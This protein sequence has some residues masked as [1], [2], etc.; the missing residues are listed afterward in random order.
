M[1]AAIVP[2]S[3]GVPPAGLSVSLGLFHRRWFCL[4]DVSGETPETAGGTPALPALPAA[5]GS[6]RLANLGSISGLLASVAAGASPARGNREARPPSSL[7]QSP[8]PPRRLPYNFHPTLVL[9]HS[10]LH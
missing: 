5:A 2:G 10:S 3:A 4:E 7:L 1:S 9:K 6:F 8:P